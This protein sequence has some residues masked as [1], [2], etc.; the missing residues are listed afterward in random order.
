MGAAAKLI[1]VSGLQIADVF[2]K[3][4]VVVHL[5][6]CE[7]SHVAIINLQI[8]QNLQINPIYERRNSF[9]LVHNLQIM[10]NLKNILRQHRHGKQH[11]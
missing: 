5:V 1:I 10:D 3:I 7:Y 6:N 8:K 2:Q 9:P 4:N 11:L